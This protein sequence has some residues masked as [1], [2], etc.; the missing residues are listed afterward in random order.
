MD[1]GLTKRPA[2]VVFN[3]LSD[4]VFEVLSQYTA[5]PWP[6]ML[7]QC[8]RV[9]VDPANLTKKGLAEALPHIVSGVARFT[10][11]EKA[12]RVEHALRA[13]L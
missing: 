13:L 2:G 4:A 9:A 8:K 7:A 12:S 1:A 11:P 3:A 5:F 10:S 6:V